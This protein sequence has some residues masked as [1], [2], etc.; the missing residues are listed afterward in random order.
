MPITLFHVFDSLVTVIS[1]SSV[2]GQLPEPRGFAVL[3][4][5]MMAVLCRNRKTPQHHI[6][7]GKQTGQS[8]PHQI[9]PNLLFQ[10]PE[11]PR[12]TV[13]YTEEIAI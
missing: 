1:T 11:I 13:C 10:I 3:S 12:A 2:Y 8:Q 9:A 7:S 6:S 5:L 4:K